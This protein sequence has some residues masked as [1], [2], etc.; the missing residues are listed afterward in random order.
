MST[1]PADDA[2]IEVNATV[3]GM[4]ERITEL[5][6]TID[7]AAMPV[8]VRL[9]ALY[10]IANL[11]ESLQEHGRLFPLGAT[12][13]AESILGEDPMRTERSCAYC[14]KTYRCLNRPTADAYYCSLTCRADDGLLSSAHE[15][16]TRLDP[17]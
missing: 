2:D 16:S 3:K 4:V 6:M 1:A 9:L 10:Q 7:Y 11:A 12:G 13:E 14:R 5:A 15:A 17:L 8:K